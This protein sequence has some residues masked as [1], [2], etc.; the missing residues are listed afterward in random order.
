MRLS[1]HVTLNFNNNISTATVFL[2]TE[3]AFD[4]T[5]HLDLLYKLSE[6]KFSISLITLINIFL[7]QGKFSVSVE[8]GLPK[9]RY[10]YT[11]RS[12]TRF[13]PVPHIVQ[14]IY[15]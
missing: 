11:S 10:V 14:S 13:R 12:T 6:L 15:K 9:P 1:G 7:S 2:D 3:K 8:G 4:K 5:W